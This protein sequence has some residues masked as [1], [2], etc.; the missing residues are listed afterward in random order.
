M[1]TNLHEKKVIYAD[2][3]EVEGYIDEMVQKTGDLLT[4]IDE[5]GFSRELSLAK[6]KIEEAAFWIGEHFDG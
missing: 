5:I 4:F 6:T 1:D 3:L 2:D